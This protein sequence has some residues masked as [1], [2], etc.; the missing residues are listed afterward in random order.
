MVPMLN[1]SLITDDTRIGVLCKTLD[2]FEML[3]NAVKTQRPDIDCELHLS[4]TES[5]YANKAYFLNYN[6]SK[7]LQ[8][9][10]LDVVHDL[11]L[12]YFQFNELWEDDLPEFEENQTGILSLLGL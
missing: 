8:C 5:N 11:G 4:F 12:T 3:L 1:L 6:R 10:S 7:R 9:G 2:Q